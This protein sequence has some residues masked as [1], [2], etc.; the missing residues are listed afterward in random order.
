MTKPAESVRLPNGMTPI[1]TEY[2]LVKC[3]G[4][5]E[6]A[7]CHLETG[8]LAVA[9]PTGWIWKG[10]T[11]YK[12]EEGETVAD[13]LDKCLNQSKALYMTILHDHNLLGGARD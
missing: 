12:L 5:V 4:A 2:M 9:I 13:Y 8:H 10:I 6:L 3:R 7:V 11:L 1:A